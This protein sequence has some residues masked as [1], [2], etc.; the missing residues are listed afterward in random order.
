MCPVPSRTSFPFQNLCSLASH[1]EHTSRPVLQ[2]WRTAAGTQI[3][4]G[5]SG[6]VG[7][8]GRVDG[9][10]SVC[11][12]ILRLTKGPV[13]EG[14]QCSVMKKG[15]FRA[16]KVSL[17]T[18]LP[19]GPTSELKNWHSRKTQIGPC[20]NVCVLFTAVSPGAGTGAL[21]CLLNVWGESRTHRGRLL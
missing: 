14:A 21:R 9:D 20:G 5:G 3:A 2:P 8:E 17:V 10:R 6:A 4:F 15:P 13:R 18:Q 1:L 19:P 7:R 11:L 12:C 16:L